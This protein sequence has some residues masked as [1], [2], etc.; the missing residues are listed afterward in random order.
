MQTRIEEDDW[1][2]DEDRVKKHENQI[3]ELNRRNQI[4]IEERHKKHKNE[5]TTLI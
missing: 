5:I 4:E 1:P 2:V 3:K